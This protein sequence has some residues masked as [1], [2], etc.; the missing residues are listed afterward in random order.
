MD[1]Q[2]GG[3]TS[4]RTNGQ[5][6]GQ[7]GRQTGGRADGRTDGPVDG[8]VETHKDILARTYNLYIEPTY[9]CVHVY[10]MDVYIIPNR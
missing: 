10:C 3:R 1:R 7:T 6:D 8:R 4:R 2:A 9:K 5:T